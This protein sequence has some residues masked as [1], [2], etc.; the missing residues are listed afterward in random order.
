[1]KIDWALWLNIITYYTQDY[2]ANAILD[3]LYYKNIIGSSYKPK[4]RCVGECK[5]GVLLFDYISWVAYKGE[6]D[7]AVSHDGPVKA[8]LLLSPAG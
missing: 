6:S 8:V 5:V 4:F 2:Y 3:K 1:M 7:H